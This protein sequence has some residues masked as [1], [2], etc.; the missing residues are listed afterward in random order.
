MEAKYVKTFTVNGVSF[1]MISVEGGTFTMG[2]TSEQ[3]DDAES[4]EKPTHQVTLSD[5]YIGQTEVTQ[6]LWEAVMGYN[7]SNFVGSDL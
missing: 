7:P 2:A 1:K 5:Y 3:G 4:N 6:A